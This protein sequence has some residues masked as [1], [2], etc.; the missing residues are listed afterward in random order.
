MK[1]KGRIDNVLAWELRRGIEEWWVEKAL[2]NARLRQ[3]RDHYLM[4]LIMLAVGGGPPEVV[5]F[6]ELVKTEARLELNGARLYL[7]LKVNLHQL[8]PHLEEE[9]HAGVWQLKPEVLSF[10][11]FEFASMAL[12][13]TA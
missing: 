9:L 10:E 4:P 12:V 11:Q 13:P 6:V 1:I 8:K 5:G 3:E 7:L 2:A